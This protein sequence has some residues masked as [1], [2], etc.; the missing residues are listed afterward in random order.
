MN[1]PL[2]S[3]IIPVYNAAAYLDETIQSALN[4]TWPNKEIIIVDDGSTDNSLEI[5][6]K[7]RS[8]RVGIYHQANKGA[9]NAR[10][11]GLKHCTGDFIQFLD[12]DD[13]LGNEK[14]EKQLKVIAGQ[15][16][17]LAIGDIVY[18]N[19]GSDP[20]KSSAGKEWYDDTC[21]EPIDF[22]IKLYGGALIG[23]NYGGMISIHSWLTPKSVLQKAGEW[24]EEL[25]VNDDGEFFC[26]AVLAGR[27]V[28][29]IPGALNYYRKFESKGSLSSRKDIDAAKSVLKTI[30]LLAE[31][32]L[33]KT[34]GP[35]ARI[36]LGRLYW[37]NAFNFYPSHRQL[38]AEAI[39]KAKKLAPG[40]KY[41]LYH[42]GLNQ[43]LAALLGWKTVRYLQH[44]KS[45]IR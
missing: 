39:K 21:F 12:G 8:A 13:L 43:K 7:Y 4:Q 33:S 31:T 6:G 35:T 1:E 14:I 22:L 9:S 2:V 29:H 19:H 27:R 34:D 23:E 30:D 40:L 11:T 18:F 10:N 5:A 15:N 25:T 32:M 28:C 36:V 45:K 42:K 38:A 37:E 26:R 17:T 41:D 16:E 20:Y 3:I 24:N 44:V